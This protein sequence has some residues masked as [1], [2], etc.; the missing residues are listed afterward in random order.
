MH[1]HTQKGT[2]Y[3]LFYP[4]NCGSGKYISQG[5]SEKVTDNPKNRII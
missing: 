1:T 3:V 2:L 5:I 4:V